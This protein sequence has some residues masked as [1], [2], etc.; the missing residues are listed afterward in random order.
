M[1]RINRAIALLEQGQPV[2]YT[3]AGE[4]TYEN[5]RAMAGTWADYIRLDLEHNPFDMAGVRKY[6]LGLRDGSR[7]LGLPRTTPA[8]A[9]LPIDGIDEAT[10]RANA[11]MI[12]QLLGQGV[13]GLILCHAE[14]P[15]AVR[16]FVES[17][18]YPFQTSSVGQGLEQGRRGHGG[19][20]FPAQIWGLDED[21]YLTRADVWPLNPQGELL[22][23]IKAENRRALER[24]EESVAV[25]GLA[26]AEWGSGDMCMS[27]MH[28]IKPQPYPPDLAAAKARVWNACRASGVNFLCIAKPDDIIS[29]ID[30]GA[31]ILRVHDPKTA[32]IGKAHTRR[33]ATPA[34]QEG[35]P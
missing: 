21:E 12:K 16:A 18:R 9:E 11:W 23:G 8:I 7:E 15:G 32:D 2:Y 19:Q 26:F 22:L 13:H 31:R 24:V 35:R 10:V 5:G 17:A 33:P 3:N 34:K 27:F 30:Q 1:Q 20:K 14:S 29:L 25:P 4:L 6:M 28:R